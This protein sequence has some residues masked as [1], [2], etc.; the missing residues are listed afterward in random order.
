LY[1]K[2][3]TSDIQSQF[4]AIQ[5]TI[6]NI[7]NTST[8]TVNNTT[9]NGNLILNGSDLNTR[10]T[11]D[12][13]NITTNTNDIISLKS[14]RTN[15]ESNITSNTSSI[16]TLNNKTANISLS[17]STTT[18]SGNLSGN[19]TGSFNSYLNISTSNNYFQAAE[20]L[21]KITMAMPVYLTNNFVVNAHTYSYTQLDTVFNYCNSLTSS[22]Q[23]QINT[24]NTNLSSLATT[25]SLATTNTNVTTL[26]NQC[27]NISYSSGTTI[28]SGNLQVTGNESGPNGSLGGFYNISTNRGYFSA[29]E[30]TGYITLGMTTNL[31]SSLVV[32]SLSFTPIQLSNIFLYTKNL[33]SDCQTQL[34]T[35]TTNVLSNAT[36]ITSNTS[37]ITSNTTNITSNTSSITTL[38]NKTA[39]ISL[40]GSTTTIVGNLTGN[41]TGS[42]N[43]YVN[44]STS[45]GY[46]QAAESINKITLGMPVYWTNNLVIN[47]H[48]YSY[49]QLD[50]VFNYCNSLTSSAQTQLNSIATSISSFTTSIASLTTSIS[51]INNTLT[52]ISYGSSTTNINNNLFI[53]GTIYTDELTIP[54]RN[55]QSIGYIYE[56]NQATATSLTSNTPVYFYTTT[57]KILAVGTFLCNS[58]YTLQST[59]NITNVTMTTYLLY[60]DVEIYGTRNVTFYS[61]IPSF[62]NITQNTNPYVT[63][64]TS[65]G[66]TYKLYV[67]V[68]WSGTSTVSVYYDNI[69]FTKIG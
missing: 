47:A 4:T 40:S 53:L 64:I 67:N 13:T 52:N 11:T 65:T 63:N 31:T 5:N 15:D 62:Q 28:I 35:I 44:I 20:S 46:F 50:T 43:G 41:N 1:S 30:S 12:E 58:N 49:T 48:T 36:N 8:S 27:S 56:I 54:T 38:N 42:L 7:S 6:T 14:S 69:Q 32:N 55:Y 23:T 61:S 9:I 57:T 21:N 68:S 29:V 34:N 39:N 22:A 37:A 66:L 10:I 3:V 45:N 33:T 17:G 26:Q 18:I 25:T 24:I 59:S 16:S 51:N 60:N 19:N 2:N